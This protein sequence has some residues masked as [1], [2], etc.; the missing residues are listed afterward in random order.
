MLHPSDV[1]TSCQELIV[2]TA[3]VVDAAR[4]EGFL[5]FLGIC[6]WPL[7]MRHHRQQCRPKGKCLVYIAEVLRF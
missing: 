5:S 2:V 4:V 3:E 1:T 6:I 7:L